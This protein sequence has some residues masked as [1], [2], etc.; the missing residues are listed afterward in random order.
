MASL[1]PEIVTARSVE[2]GSISLAT[3]TLAP[4]H[5]RISRIFEPPAK[6][7]HSHQPG[8]DQVKL[9]P[10]MEQ[11]HIFK[12]KIPCNDA[13]E[14]ESR[15]LRRVDEPLF[16]LPMSDPH[17][18]AGTTRRRVMGGRGT[19]GLDTRLDRSSCITQLQLPQ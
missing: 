7:S 5:S 12:V 17:W 3:C 2:L 16:P 1:P 15:V 10:V 13:N 18:E 19:L 6:H 4:L 8:S 11:F 9:S 14:A